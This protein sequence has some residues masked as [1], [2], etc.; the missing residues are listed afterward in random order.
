MK[1][2]T[3]EEMREM[4]LHEVITDVTAGSHNHANFNVMRVFGGWIYIL[5]VAGQATETAFFVKER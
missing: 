5:V 4:D 2:I 1:H 3:L